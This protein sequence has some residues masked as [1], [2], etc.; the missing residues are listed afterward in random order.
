MTAQ[1]FWRAYSY[2]R[3]E[4]I[5]KAGIHKPEAKPNKPA[6]RNRKPGATS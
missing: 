3:K 2:A 4:H 1:T 6:V 5:E